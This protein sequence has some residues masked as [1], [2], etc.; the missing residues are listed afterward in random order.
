[1]RALGFAAHICAWIVV[2]LLGA[3][4]AAAADR[5]Y[6]SAEAV[7]PLTPGVVVPSV[8]VRSVRGAP[9]DLSEVVRDKGALL[10]FYR[11]GW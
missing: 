9:V 5:A 4:A 8:T 6:P 7:V 2:L 1:M 11:G 10:V 3:G